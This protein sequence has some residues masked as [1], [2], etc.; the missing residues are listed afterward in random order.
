M[1]SYERAAVGRHFHAISVVAAIER[2]SP[3]ILN[4]GFWLNDPEQ[5]II[6]PQIVSAHPRE[7][8]LW[9]KSCFEIFLGVK[10]QDYYREINLSPSQAWQAYQFDEY[11]YPEQIPPL[12]SHDID[13]VQLKKTH[14]GLSASVDLT[15]FMSEHQ[16]RWTD[17]F[18]GLTAVIQTNKQTHYFAMQHSGALPDFHNKHDW[19]QSF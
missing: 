2:Q 8:F 1:A 7:D 16:L 19:L 12:P 5:S 11:R 9:E 6:W 17:L 14:F 3:N 18:V 10:N 4:V 13:L 15:M